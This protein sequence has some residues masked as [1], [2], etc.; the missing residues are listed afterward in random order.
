MKNK[1]GILAILG[2]ILLIIFLNKGIT[3]QA[4]QIEPEGW[5]VYNKNIKE[6]G[7]FQ[8]YVQESTGRAFIT[9]YL[10]NA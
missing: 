2:T 10:G 4:Q 6:C 9:G 5:I 3:V 1:K 7:D 8:Y